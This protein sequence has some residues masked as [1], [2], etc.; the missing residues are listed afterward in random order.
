[1]EGTNYSFMS[2]SS[3]STPAVPYF[4]CIFARDS[5]DGG[6]GYKGALPWKLK[7]DMIHFKK[8]TTFNTEE[9]E[10]V[11]IMGRRTWEGMGGKPLHKRINIVVSKSLEKIEG[12]TLAS[13]LDDA[14]QKAMGFGK[15]RYI[16]VIGGAA[17]YREAFKHPQMETIYETKVSMYPDVEYDTF[18]DVCIPLD[19]E[20]ITSGEV[21]GEN[22]RLEFLQYNKKRDTSER[23]Y[24]NLVKEIL[25]TGE[26]RGDRTGTGTISVYGLQARFDIREFFP[27]IT[28]KT[29]GLKTIFEELIWMLRGQT[30][31]NTLKR[32]KVNIW[33]DNS[34]SHH[35][36][37]VTRG[38]SHADGDLGPLYGYNW[39]SFGGDY[40]HVVFV[41]NET[42]EEKIV[43]EDR[44]HI[45]EG[46]DQIQYII[47]E[48]KTNPESRRIMFSGWNP[49]TLNDIAL[50]SC[51][52]LCQF[53]IS[54]KKYL[55]CKL[56]M[57]SND[58]FLGAPF[59]VAQYSLL[60]YMIASMT[61]YTPGDLIYSLGDAHIYLNHVE[62]MKR[63]LLRPLRDLPTL[64]VLRVPE[65]IE[66]FEFS[67]FKLSGYYSH[68]SIKGVMAV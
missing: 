47:D 11:L 42:E 14:L 62:Q 30:N 29:V 31:N 67:D 23:A 18:F 19:F 37:M 3:S 13:S 27:L 53:Y 61:G 9:K 43:L 65:K 54:R 16:F 10:N 15:G 32:K 34:D 5:I 28:T 55:H 26:E 58:I 1:M 21:K 7:D 60:T 38:V 12:V 68:P 33:T 57:R 2:S 46:F 56:Y 66:D 36:K 35:K 45:G 40:R 24:L 49:S 59:N 44:R 48:I 8:I 20:K 39:R 41:E 4:S 63:Q 52:V 50:P 17:L 25:E 6:I 22:F 51:H 64:S